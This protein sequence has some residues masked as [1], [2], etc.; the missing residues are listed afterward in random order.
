[1]ARGGGECY[2]CICRMLATATASWHCHLQPSYANDDA[3]CVANLSRTSVVCADAPHGT[4][5]TA[6]VLLLG[7]RMGMEGGG[8]AAIQ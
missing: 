7:H 1:M 3:T 6:T 5:L 2:Q 4:D 8:A